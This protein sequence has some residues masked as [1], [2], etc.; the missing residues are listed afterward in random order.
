M[1]FKITCGL[2]QWVVR[3]GV[4]EISFG[5]GIYVNCITLYLLHHRCI[6]FSDQHFLKNLVHIGNWLDMRDVEHYVFL[7]LSSTDVCAT[8][9]A[10]PDLIILPSNAQH[11]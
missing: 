8:Q 10:F 7:D 1:L 4:F 11:P 2:K 3:L 5:S 6:V 9:G